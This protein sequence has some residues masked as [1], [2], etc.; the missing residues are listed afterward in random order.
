MRHEQIK[1]SASAENQI[2]VLYTR[3]TYLLASDWFINDG[4]EWYLGIGTKCIAEFSRLT[5]KLKKKNLIA[6]LSLFFF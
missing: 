1:V 6:E 3:A 2:N 4:I 5:M